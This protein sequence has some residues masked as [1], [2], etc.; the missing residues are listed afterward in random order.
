MQAGTRAK[1]RDYIDD[2]IVAGH[3]APTCPAAGIE[4]AISKM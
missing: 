1:A 2:A 3:A 4:L